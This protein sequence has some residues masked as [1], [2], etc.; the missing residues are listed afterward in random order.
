MK[1]YN[2]FKKIQGKAEILGCLDENWKIQRSIRE[3]KRKGEIHE[4]E[5]EREG[6]QMLTMAESGGDGLRPN[7]VWKNECNS[8]DK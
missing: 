2:S 5:R 8:H 1:V 4:G 7:L 6:L 3:S